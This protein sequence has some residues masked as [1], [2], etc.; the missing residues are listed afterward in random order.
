MCIRW[1]LIKE[2]Q[3]TKKITFRNVL[4]VPSSLADKYEGWLGL[5]KFRRRGITQ[6]K[7][8][9]IQNTAKV[10]NQEHT[11]K[12]HETNI[13]ALS[14]IP[15]HDPKIQAAAD[16]RLRSHG[17]RL[18]PETQGFRLAYM[19]LRR[20]GRRTALKCFRPARFGSHVRSVAIWKTKLQ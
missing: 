5:Q 11:K 15:T 12:N 18:P 17:D 3:H 4:S 14:G 8:Y 19:T 2:F 6:K 1:I 16:L 9:N 20:P 7:A 10:W 13:H